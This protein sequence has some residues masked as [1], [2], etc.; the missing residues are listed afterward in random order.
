MF[1]VTNTNDFNFSASYNGDTYT[2]PKNKLVSC[3]DEAVSHIFGLDQTDK[4]DVLSRHG[5]ITVTG[6][7]VDGLAILSRFKF[8]VVK[9]AV[10]AESARNAHGP[11][12]MLQA[13]DNAE[14]D[15]DGSAPKLSA[16]RGVGVMVGRQAP[17]Y[18]PAPKAA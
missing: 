5:W 3:E 2:F 18:G 8:D 15:T 6:P 14:A 9:P 12:P 4:T 17:S 16:S 10:E 11:A 1:R 13:A 7:K